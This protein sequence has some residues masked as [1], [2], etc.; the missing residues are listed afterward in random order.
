MMNTNE[1]ARHDVTVAVVREKGAR[2][3]IKRASIDPPRPDDVHP[4]SRGRAGPH[5][6]AMVPDA[7][8]ANHLPLNRRTEGYAREGIDLNV[9]TLADWAGACTATL[10]PL[11]SAGLDTGDEWGHPFHEAASPFP[12]PGVKRRLSSLTA[13]AWAQA[14]KRS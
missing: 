10:A 9:S 8:F 2:F 3:Q 13:T 6:L 11:S 4:I 14:L 5:P 1:D 7:K 12:D